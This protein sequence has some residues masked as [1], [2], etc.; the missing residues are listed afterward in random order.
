MPCLA[1]T[2]C[3]WC[4]WF[5]SIIQPGDLACI[6]LTNHLSCQCSRWAEASTTL[7]LEQQLWAWPFCMGLVD[8]Q[9]WFWELH[10]CLDF[11]SYFIS[12]SS[13]LPM[14]LSGTTTD[15]SWLKR[16]E[17]LCIWCHFVTVDF[18]W[19]SYT[20][21]SCSCFCHRV[22]WIATMWPKKQFNQLE[23]QAG[24]HLDEFVFCLVL[25]MIAKF[26]HTFCAESFNPETPS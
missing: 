19:L 7:Q 5:A 9:H 25:P 22:A 16:N 14:P 3:I 26:S 17:R 8:L 4:C 13:P 18:F 11:C 12:C 15:P 20:Q 21:F 24:W 1:A 23:W 2:S 6:T 10:F